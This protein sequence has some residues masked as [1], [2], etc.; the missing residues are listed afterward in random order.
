MSMGLKEWVTIAGIVFVAGGGW[1]LNQ[2]Q[3]KAIAATESDVER[4]EAHQ[5]TD[6]LVQQQLS[7]Q[8]QSIDEKVDKID[9]K[10]ETMSTEQTAIRIEQVQQRVMLNSILDA[11]KQP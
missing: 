8:M 9:L 2:F 6:T 7:S 4:L 5:V 3:E 10:Q 1:T 11:V